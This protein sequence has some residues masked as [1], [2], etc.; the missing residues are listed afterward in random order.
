MGKQQSFNKRSKKARNSAK[1]KIGKEGNTEGKMQKHP[2]KS[3]KHQGKHAETQWETAGK[4]YET[5][6]T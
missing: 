1:S 5:V 6:E 3:Q 2:R 4:G